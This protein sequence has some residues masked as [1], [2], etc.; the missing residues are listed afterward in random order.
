MEF[1][2]SDEA[3]RIYAELNFEYPVKPGV[4]WSDRVKSWGDFKPDTISLGEVAKR[5]PLASEMVDQVRFNE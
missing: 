3:Q 5:I 4:A 2:A 1:L